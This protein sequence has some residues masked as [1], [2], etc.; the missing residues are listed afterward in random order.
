MPT[1]LRLFATLVLAAALFSSAQE[2]RSQGQFVHPGVLHSRQELDFV[3]RQIAK[4]NEPWQSAWEELRSHP[5]SKL[6]WNPSPT[7]EVV[8]GP[9]NNPDVG[10][11]DLMRDGAAAYSHAVQWYMTNDRAHADKAI[12]IL[13]AYATTLQ[14]VGGHDAKLLVGMSGINYVNAAEILRHTSPHWSDDKQLAFERLLRQ[15]LYPVIEDFYPSANG[16]WDAAMIQTMLAMGVFLDDRAMFDPAVDYYLH[17]KGN[18]AVRNYINDFGQCQESGRDQSHTQ[19]GLGYLGCAA[20]IAWKQ[21][22]DLYGAYDNRLALG[23]EYTARY[24][25]GH[26]V[27]YVPYRSYQ[28]RY[29]YKTISDKGRGR[30]SSIY[31][32]VYHHYHVRVGIEM[33]FTAQVVKQIRPEKWQT[34]FAPWGTL[35]Y[36]ELPAFSEASVSV[37]TE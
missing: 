14:S 5:I 30:F 6:D 10:G 31:E 13:H 37:R 1:R 29:H 15:V 12:E 21:G 19:M 11:T 22:V 34:A 23:Y 33:P 35:M 24:N 4:G 3:R 20:E 28:G 18:G 17:G 36:A 7:A 8:R 32:R 2:A 9:Y 25:L 16:N 27:R 26:D